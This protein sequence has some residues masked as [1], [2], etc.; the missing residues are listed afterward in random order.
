LAGYFGYTP[1]EREGIA[2]TEDAGYVSVEEGTSTNKI[3][4][5]PPSFFGSVPQSKREIADNP[6]EAR[7][8]PSGPSVKE[9]FLAG[10]FSGAIYPGECLLQ[11][12]APIQAQVSPKPKPVEARNGLLLCL[13]SRASAHEGETAG[14]IVLFPD[15]AS[16]WTADAKSVADSLQQL[17]GNRFSILPGD[18]QKAAHDGSPGKS[19][20]LRSNVA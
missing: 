7:W 12:V 20:K 17:V 15:I 16:V 18:A 5:T 3:S 2:E 10:G 4:G 13:R 1:Q 14:D 6:F 8:A 19:E 9:K 11:L